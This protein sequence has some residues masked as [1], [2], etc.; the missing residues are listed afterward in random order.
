MCF[1]CG[2]IIEGAAV[3]GTVGKVSGAA[4]TV[5]AVKGVDVTRRNSKRVQPKTQQIAG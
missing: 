4:R 1:G 3:T 5:S 2:P